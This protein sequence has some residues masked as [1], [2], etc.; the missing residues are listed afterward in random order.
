MP[1]ILNLRENMY[2]ADCNYILIAV[3]FF[4]YLIVI[5]WEVAERHSSV[6]LEAPRGFKSLQGPALCVK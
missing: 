3:L 5:C 2:Q 6:K 4:F 1:Y